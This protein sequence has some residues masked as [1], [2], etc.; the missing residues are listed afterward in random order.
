[1]NIDS[2][3]LVSEFEITRLKLYLQQNPEESYR[4]AIAHFEDF[5]LLVQEYQKLQLAFDLLESEYSEF[6]LSS[7]AK[8]S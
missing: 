6:I 1:M 7:F 4:L 2:L 5:L 3:P 8:S